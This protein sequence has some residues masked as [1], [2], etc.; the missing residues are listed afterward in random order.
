MGSSRPTRCFGSIQLVD[1][2]YHCPTLW[3]AESEFDQ[4][5]FQFFDTNVLSIQ[6]TCWIWPKNSF[7]EFIAVPCP[8]FDVGSSSLSSR[9]S[10][11]GARHMFSAEYTMWR[12]QHIQQR[13]NPPK[14]TLKI[15]HL[16][17]LANNRDRHICQ[18]MF[19]ACHQNPPRDG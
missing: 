15:A 12:F 17:A 11:L 6:R 4:D 7:S 9:P 14:P 10:P 18:H 3:D 8:A 2:V 5:F 16:E 1:G 19:N 13:C